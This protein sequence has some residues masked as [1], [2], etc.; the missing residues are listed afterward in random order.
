MN[1]GEW[2]KIILACVATAAVCFAL[3]RPPEPCQ[4]CGTVQERTRLGERVKKWIA[5][6]YITRDRRSSSA[7]AGSIRAGE[8]D[9]LQNREPGGESVDHGHGW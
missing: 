7:D 1:R 6:W 2:T 3:F 8:V 9:R 4:K 5:I